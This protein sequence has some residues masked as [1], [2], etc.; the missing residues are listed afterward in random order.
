MLFNNSPKVKNY[1]FSLK[2]L[3]VY[4]LVLNLNVLHCVH[5]VNCK[6]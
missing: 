3:I 6:F 2:I 4:K 5:I 1:V